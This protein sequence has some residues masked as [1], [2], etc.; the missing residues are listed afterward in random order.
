MNV[1]ND[2]PVLP[3]P[4]PLAEVLPAGCLLAAGAALYSTLLIATVE[5]RIGREVWLDWFQIGIVLLRDSGIRMQPG[6]RE[7]TAG[8]FVHNSAA[9]IY[10]LIFFGALARWTWS[11]GPTRLLMAAPVWAL[12][13]AAVEYYVILPIA[14]RTLRMQVPFWTPFLWHVAATITYPAFPWVRHVVTGL[15]VP[16]VAFGRRSAFALG[17]VGLLACVPAGMA[18]AG[19]D[20]RGPIHANVDDRA[21]LLQM[22]NH[23]EVGIAM[24]RL[25]AD[26]GA[27]H[28]V[29]ALARLMVYEQFREDVLMRRWWR[30]WF[31][32]E[33]PEMTSGE[34][35]HLPGM[36][37]LAE[38]GDLEQLAGAA[39]DRRFLQLMIRH[40]EGGVAIASHATETASDLRVRV[41]AAAI[42]YPLEHQITRMHRLLATR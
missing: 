39:L 20:V 32:G 19:R 3:R 6:W 38:L 8:L 12:V 4:A 15:P 31:G 17:L 42:R 11:F 34:R 26:R 10:G 36:P 28:R 16:R 37:A 18:A 30:S 33:L 9:F 24:A 13:T 25:A 27:D 23:H 22:T 41:L 35:Q 5:P 21:F 29:R 7:F 40:H 1:P 14:G 2:V